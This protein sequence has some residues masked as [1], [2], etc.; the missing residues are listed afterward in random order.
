MKEKKLIT[1]S[2]VIYLLITIITFVID[3]IWFDKIKLSAF[4]L[5][6]FAGIGYYVFLRKLKP[7]YYLGI[8]GFTF[9]AEYLGAM[10]SLYRIFPLYDM[11]LHFSSGILLVFFASYLLELLLKKSAVKN[12]PTNVSAWFCFFGSVASAALW[13][14]WE[15][16]GDVLF[17]LN[18]QLGSLNDTMEDIA[19][20]TIGAVFGVILLFAVLK[21]RKNK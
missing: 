13:E 15:F 1:L 4:L 16:S 8:L 9:L 18:S 6:L 19:A 20:G 17:K 11:L 10:L 5:C 12:I 14:I 2:T 7:I 3:R 21:Q